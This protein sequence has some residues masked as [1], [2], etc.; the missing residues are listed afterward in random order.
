MAVSYGFR[1]RVRR[2]RL[3]RRCARVGVG[4]MGDDT[5]EPTKKA[6]SAT[7]GNRPDKGADD[8]E[9]WKKATYAEGHY[10]ILK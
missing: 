3:R 10:E 5:K 8:Y 9:V 1:A 6:H 7:Y 2:S 4:N